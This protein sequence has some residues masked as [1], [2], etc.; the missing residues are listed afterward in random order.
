LQN[1]L[2]TSEQRASITEQGKRNLEEES[3]TLC[4]LHIGSDFQ[5]VIALETEILRETMAIVYE[6]MAKLHHTIAP[7]VAIQTHS[8]ERVAMLKEVMIALDKIHEWYEK[9]PEAPI[10]VPKK[11]WIA[12]Q[13]TR[14]QLR[15]KVQSREKLVKDAERVLASYMKLF[16]N[17]ESVIQLHG[18]PSIGKIA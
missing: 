1:K 4:L 2:Y 16:S 17:L 18:S 10:V 8:K 14:V 7:I 9:Y 13:N 3:V 15:I 11:A 6:E 12:M 5:T